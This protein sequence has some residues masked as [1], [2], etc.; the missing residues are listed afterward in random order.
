MSTLKHTPRRRSPNGLGGRALWPWILLLAAGGVLPA[1]VSEESVDEKVA[2]LLGSSSDR[3]RSEQNPDPRARARDRSKVAGQYATTPP[4]TNPRSSELSFNPAPEARDVEAR[5]NRMWHETGSYLE[6]VQEPPSIDATVDGLTDDKDKGD[7][8]EPDRP[9]AEPAKERPASDQAKP[10]DTKPDQPKPGDPK[11][12]DASFSAHQPVPATGADGQPIP[13]T[14]PAERVINPEANPARVDRPENPDA[15][16]GPAPRGAASIDLQLSFKIAQ[17]SSPEHRNQEDAYLLTAISLLIE[18]HLWTPRLSNNT[19]VQMQGSGDEGRYDNAVRLVNDLRATQ[20]LP[21]GG[22][23]EAAWVWEASEQLRSSVTDQ[24]RQASRLLL[25]GNIPLLKNA[26]LIARESLIQSERNLIYAARDY[27]RFRRRFLVDIANDYFDLVQQ[28]SQIANQERSLRSRKN[29]EK[30]TTALFEAGRK[31][32]FEKNIAS[33]DVKQALSGLLNQRERYALSLDRFKVRLGLPVEEVIA[34]QD[35]KFEMFEPEVS[36][37]DATTMALAYRLDLQNQRDRVEDAQRGVANARNQLLPD[38]NVNGS[39]TVPT[40]DDTREGGAFFDPDQANYLLGMTLGLPL[41]RHNE[42]MRVRQTQI[43]FERQKRDLNVAQDNVVIEVRSALRGIEL[44]RIQLQLANDRVVIADRRLEEQNLKK[45]IVKP[46]EIVD[47][48]NE[49]VAAENQRDQAITDL[50][51][52]VLNYLL[53]SDQLRV[54]RDGTFEP[55][56][57]MPVAPQP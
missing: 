17:R 28:R 47:S 53:A 19:T 45:A 4:T 54:A 39:V 43:Q 49:L 29:L 3:V 37:T 10:E 55:L 57:G 15:P 26:G 14:P 23:V 18:R 22:Q 40:D 56:P 52:A 33:S 25:T 30:A 44:A 5:L 31:N 1:C 13:P 2:R 50:R 20:R 21:Y 34:I 35:L 32:A 24:Y 41:D 7:E 46:Q 48:V 9:D 16:A 42:A 27:E 12:G 38:L 8:D 6:V 36:L 51:N 11:G